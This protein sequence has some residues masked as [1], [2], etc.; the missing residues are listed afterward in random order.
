MLERL[1]SII[2]KNQNWVEVYPS[3]TISTCVVEPYNTLTTHW[4]LDHTEVSV[5]LDNEAI[6]EI[7]QKCLDR[8][9]H[10]M[11]I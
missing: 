1:L 7:C 5:V 9:D 3:S 2:E 11:I 4:L 10:H 8:K 6:Y